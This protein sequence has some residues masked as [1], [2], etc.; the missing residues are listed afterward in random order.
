MCILEE[1]RDDSYIS[2]SVMFGFCRYEAYVIQ[3][4]FFII[5]PIVS[6]TFD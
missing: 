4:L 1:I 2:F 3:T 6:F 5:F